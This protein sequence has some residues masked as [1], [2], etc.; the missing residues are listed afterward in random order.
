MSRTF[1]AVTVEKKPKQQ[2]KK[3]SKKQR[4]KHKALPKRYDRAIR[5]FRKK[6]EKTVRNL[7]VY[8]QEEGQ[9]RLKTLRDALTFMENAKINRHRIIFG[10]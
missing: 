5:S 2:K 3:T 1:T 9:K 6:I 7:T 4:A 8:S 10:Y